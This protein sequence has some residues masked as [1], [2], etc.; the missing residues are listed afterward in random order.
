MNLATE[1]LVDLGIVNNALP[2]GVQAPT[3]ELTDVTTKKVFHSAKALEEGPL[4]VVF[5][6]GGWCPYCNLAN[7]ALE[8]HYHEI[9]AAGAQLVVISPETPDRIEKTA[10]EHQL[11]FPA[12]CDPNLEVARKFG[13]VFEFS[14]DLDHL[15]VNSFKLDLR[16][17][18][19]S[20]RAELPLPATYI[21]AQDGH[22]YHRFVDA[23]YKRREEPAYIVKHVKE[24]ATLKPKKQE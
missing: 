23:D 22:V 2:M 11:S 20:E 16:K 8:R 14:K 18:N 9:R 4:V 17:I 1:E 7:K 19:H 6:R 5:Y 3:F 21:I 12:L 24:L 10:Q 13:L 15:Y